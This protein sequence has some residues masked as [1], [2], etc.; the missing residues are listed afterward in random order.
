MFVI[1]GGYL[2]EE[3]LCVG[4]GVVAWEVTYPYTTVI[5]TLLMLIDDMLVVIKVVEEAGLIAP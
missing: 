2:K 5:S 4:F 3:E 1:N